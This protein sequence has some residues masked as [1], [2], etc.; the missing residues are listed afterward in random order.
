MAA[1]PR[2]RE[3]HPEMMPILYH[4]EFL[5]TYYSSVLSL[6][7]AN[8]TTPNI[9]KKLSIL[10][11]LFQAPKLREMM[12]KLFDIYSR[13]LVIPHDLHDGDPTKWNYVGNHGTGY[14]AMK[15]LVDSY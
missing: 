9:V 1:S 11:T 5:Q 12:L 3:S 14:H 15:H 7:S 10:P 6:Y 13:T 8:S 2:F 4:L